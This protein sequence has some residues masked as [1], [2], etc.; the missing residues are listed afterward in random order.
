MVVI[1]NRVKVIERL[2][3]HEMRVVALTLTD[4]NPALLEIHKKQ[5]KRFK[6]LQMESLY[7]DDVDIT[8]I[9]E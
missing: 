5:V 4:E 7:D 3:F 2:N 1:Y 6:K 9:T 8:T